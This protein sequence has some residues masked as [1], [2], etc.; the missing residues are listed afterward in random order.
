MTSPP[1]RRGTRSAVR[2]TG[3][4]A[5]K[6][7]I[8]STSCRKTRA[9]AAPCSSIPVRNGDIR[10]K[11][12]GRRTAKSTAPSP[13]IPA[14]SLLLRQ[15]RPAICRYCGAA[16]VGRRQPD[17]GLAV[18]SVALRFRLSDPE[19]ALR[20]RSVVPVRRRYAVLIAPRD[21]RRGRCP[22]SEVRKGWRHVLMRTSESKGH[23]QI[24]DASAVFGFEVPIRICRLVL[25]TS[26]PPH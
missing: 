14:Q 22:N 24:Y 8:R 5:S 1:A 2:T 11:R 25:G 9:S 6:C 13:P 16:R 15:L 4:R 7:N 19:T 26:N 20:P 21:L 18:R 3:A 17:L 23:Q 12:R 10:A